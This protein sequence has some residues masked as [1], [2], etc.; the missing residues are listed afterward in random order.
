MTCGASAAARRD[1]VLTSAMNAAYRRRADLDA[2]ATRRATA[3]NGATA[4]SR[5]RATRLRW[6]AS[7]CA[8]ARGTARGAGGAGARARRRARGDQR[9]GVGDDERLDARGRVRDHLHDTPEGREELSGPRARVPLQRVRRGTARVRPQAQREARGR[10]RRRERL[11]S[12]HGGRVQLERARADFVDFARGARLA[13][14][15]AEVVGRVGR[16]GNARGIDRFAVRVIGRLR[17]FR[18]VPSGA[19][20]DNVRIWQ[21][22]VPRRVDLEGRR[23]RGEQEPAR[24][25]QLVPRGRVVRQHERRHEQ[26]RR[27]RGE[28]VRRHRALARVVVFCCYPRKRADTLEKRMTLGTDGQ[29]KPRGVCEARQ[30]DAHRARSPL[31]HGDEGDAPDA[32]RRVRDPPRARRT[33]ASRQPSDFRDRAL[34]ILRARRVPRQP[35]DVRGRVQPVGDPG[36]SPHAGDAPA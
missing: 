30:H 36:A 1:L 31:A 6:R 12:R 23:R 29:F 16:V 22:G 20:L 28:R 10:H 9:G 13:N 15:E 3:T 34:G 32:P 27:E 24:H 21:R 2:E 33:G 19:P 8:R 35:R 4:R 26:A 11:A 18:R 17:P 14:A 25:Q 5:A 7:A